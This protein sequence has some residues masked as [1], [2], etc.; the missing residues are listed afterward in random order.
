MYLLTTSTD[1]NLSKPSSVTVGY[2]VTY[3]TKFN[4]RACYRSP[5][6]KPK[7]VIVLASVL[8]TAQTYEKMRP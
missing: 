7:P 8:V 3:E 6:F 5:V 1:S 4:L 2:T